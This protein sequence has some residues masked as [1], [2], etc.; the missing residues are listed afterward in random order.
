M[1]QLDLSRF[2]WLQAHELD[3]CGPLTLSLRDKLTKEQ[4]FCSE[5]FESQAVSRADV[6]QPGPASVEFLEALLL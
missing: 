6:A 3:L 1:H 2:K 4:Q 5:C